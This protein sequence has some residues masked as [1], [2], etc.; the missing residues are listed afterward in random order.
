M[1]Q[2]ILVDSD[3]VLQNIRECVLGLNELGVKTYMFS[4]TAFGSR[5]F[6]IMKK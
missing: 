2:A 5:Q 6:K 4:M 3:E 1:I